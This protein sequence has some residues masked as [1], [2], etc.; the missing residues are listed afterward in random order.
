MDAREILS[1]VFVKLFKSLHSFDSAK[2][3]FYG[4]FNRMIV[5]EAIDHIKQ[6]SKFSSI[7]ASEAYEP[8]IESSV[9]E[10]MNEA[11]IL[12]MIQQLPPS[13]HA[14]FVLFVI[15]GYPHKEIA[16]QLSI[17][18]GTSKWHLSEARKI[19]QHKIKMNKTG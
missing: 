6:R 4:W 8:H 15:E 16:K 19:L 17:S 13:T 3:N 5:N 12:D 7:E 18:E 2:G 11:A 10:A 1:D 9:I 14:V